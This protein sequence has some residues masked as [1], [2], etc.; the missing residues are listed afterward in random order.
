[1]A[2]ISQ[3]SRGT[4][5]HVASGAAPGLTQVL[6]PL[7]VRETG[8]KNNTRMKHLKGHVLH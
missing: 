7:L 5:V 3:Q 8:E 6:S 2:S 1:M 4:S